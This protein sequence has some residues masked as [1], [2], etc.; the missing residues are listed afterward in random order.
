MRITTNTN[1]TATAT[2]STKLDFARKEASKLL[3]IASNLNVE[4]YTFP[5]SDRK[6]A[7]KLKGKLAKW[8]EVD[9]ALAGAHTN[10][11]AKLDQA[12][13]ALQFIAG[14]LESLPE[15]YNPGA[16]KKARG[17]S[18]FII[19]APVGVKESRLEEY[20]G[21]IE[22]PRCLRVIEVRKSV[23]MV[24]T[25]DGLRFPVAKAALEVIA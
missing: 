18:K 11:L 9:E 7:L 1:D 6:G 3:N 13:A 25:T 17:G 5:N 10:A 8:A 4:Q 24:E 22:D 14:H 21:L 19:G 2:A 20:E 23:V 12:V 15:G 16:P